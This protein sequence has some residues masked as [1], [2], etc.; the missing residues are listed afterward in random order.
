MSMEH[1]WNDTD[2][3]RTAALGEIHISMH[4]QTLVV[5]KH[6]VRTAQ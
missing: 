2:S 5:Y 6:S 4:G 3:G 1:W